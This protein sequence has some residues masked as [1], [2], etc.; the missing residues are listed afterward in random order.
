[1]ML[2]HIG[3]SSRNIEK[4]ISFF[5]YFGYSIKGN[6]R[7]DNLASIKVQ[8]MEAEG[9]PDIELVENLKKGDGP[10]TPHLQAKRKIFHYAY[11][12]NSI[13]KKAQ[14]IIDLHGGFYLVPIQYV[15]DTISDIYAWCYLM[16]RNM[17]IIELVQ[18]KG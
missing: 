1:M 3:I 16:F 14:E 6:L 17:M 15:D 5:T 10:M 8:F 12:T 11:E 7:E 9:Q 18:V 2:H 4:D 13:E